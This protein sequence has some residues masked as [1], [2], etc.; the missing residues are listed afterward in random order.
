MVDR[1]SHW[2]RLL[3]F[4]V[5]DAVRVSSSRRLTE[6][7]A[8]PG[9]KCE[10]VRVTQTRNTRTAR[11]N[12]ASRSGCPGFSGIHARRWFVIFPAAGIK[13]RIRA[14]ENVHRSL[15]D[16][17]VL[18][19]AALIWLGPIQ[20]LVALLEHLMINRIITR[21]SWTSCAACLRVRFE[22]DH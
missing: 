13:C 10:A 1:S 7:L 4:R 22:I 2:A 19:C 11:W 14:F 18:D 20:G 3:Y 6:R 9:R 21:Q 15:V 5:A 16:W 8:S 12:D 17:I